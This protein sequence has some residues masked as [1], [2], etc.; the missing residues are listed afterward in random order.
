MTRTSRQR[1]HSIACTP[2]RVPDTLRPGPDTL[3][4]GPDAPRPVPDAPRPVPRTHRR[5]L[6]ASFKSIVPESIF[7]FL[8]PRADAR[9]SPWRL[10]LAAILM[11]ISARDTLAARWD[12]LRVWMR[13]LL[14]GRRAVGRTYQ[15]FAK[16]MAR[17]GPRI[18]ARIERRLR[19][20]TA[21]LWA[22]APQANLIFGWQVFAVDGTKV[23]L[24]RVAALEQ[25]FG[26][27]AKAKSTP[28]ALLTCLIHL[29]TG[30]PWGYCVGRA[31]ASE[32]GH[33]CSMRRLLPIGSLLVADAG[34]VGYA[35][36]KALIGDE[37]SRRFF[38]IRVGANVKLLHR[39]GWPIEQA[40]RVVYL[41]PHE[42]RRAGEAPLALRLIR[43]KS[44]EGRKIWL[45]T[46]VLCKD[47][48]SDD[49][50]AAIYR[51]RWEIEVFYRTFK[52][53]MNSHKTLS[54]SPR[55]ATMELRFAMISLWLLRLLT[56]QSQ[57]AAGQS[58]LRMS[59]AD[60]LKCLRQMLRE[61]ARR[62]RRGDGLRRRL[63]RAQRDNYQ[64]RSSKRARHWPHKKTDKPPGRPRLNRATDTQVK[65]AKQFERSREVI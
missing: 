13:S 56:A 43:V 63:A 2:R 29:A 19:R 12:D 3:R 23:D 36:L 24:P 22:A 65:Q 45:L 58:P 20:V 1:D 59:T 5:D 26:I 48:L 7:A 39:L 49:H 35:L 27:A 31:D 47:R 14:P 44:A 57:V 16:M 53:T 51:T 60:A 8:Q 17:W 62:L 33:L 50:A 54:Q 21:A 10:A 42:R 4:P 52:Q 64:R 37:T 15:G 28:Q 61:P 32:R 11:S 34:F 38:L 6:L 18:V 25:D 9:W 41:W 30:V 46:N 40:G 55:L